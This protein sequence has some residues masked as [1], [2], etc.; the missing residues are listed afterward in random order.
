MLLI[1]CHEPDKIIKNLES[2]VQARVLVLKYGDYSFSDTVIERKTLSDFFCSLKN[3]RL[4]EQMECI[5]RY[6]TEK[7][8][9]IEGFFDFSY[10]SNISYLYSSLIDIALN[11]DVKIIFSKDEDQTAAIIKRI[12]RQRNF[13]SPVN[14]S[15]K[16]KIYHATRFF[17]IGRKKLEILFDRYGSIKNIANTDKKELKGIK[18]I[19]KKTVEKTINKLES[20]I[21]R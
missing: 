8:L 3:N 5:S 18:S 7:Y 13:G 10:V 19:G 1:D 17:E 16:D 14:I 4:N 12:Y 2:S 6:Y 11:F 15:K 20:N 21:F 9:L